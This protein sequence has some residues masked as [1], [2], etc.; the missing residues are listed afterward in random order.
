MSDTAPS[1]T[2]TMHPDFD[3]ADADVTLI[4]GDETPTHFRM[5]SSHLSRTSEFFRAMF[6]LP[7]SAGEGAA[8]LN[9]DEDALTLEILLKLA[10]GLPPGLAR[11]QLIDEVARAL[12]AAEKYGMKGAEEILFI[13]LRGPLSQVDPLRTYILACRHGW[14]DVATSA[15]E[16][17]VRGPLE[18]TQLPPM[19]TAHLVRVLVARQYRIDHFSTA[20]STSAVFAYDNGSTACCRRYPGACGNAAFPASATTW[21]DFK[22]FVLAAYAKAPSVD[23]LLSNL[24]LAVHKGNLEGTFCCSRVCLKPIWPWQSVI[25]DLRRC[26]A[27]TLP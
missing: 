16:K 6:E 18:L 22:I 27:V 23:A 4:S 15:L 14:D 7:Q 26:E 21:R 11:L 24:A 19:E 3:D 12:A 25:D 1:P 10:I 13:Q 20:L 8:C 9:L 2:H 5:A 17:V